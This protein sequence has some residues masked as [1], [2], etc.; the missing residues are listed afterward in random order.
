VWT[1]A[2]A[3]GLLLVGR[4]LFFSP[5]TLFG[6]EIYIYKAGYAPA[7]SVLLILLIGF[8]AANIFFW[9]RSLLLSF[10][11][12]ELPLRVSFLAMVA[13]VSLAF[14]LVPTLGY[15]AEAALFSAYFVISVSVLVLYGMAEIRKRSRLDPGLP[16]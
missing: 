2:V 1:G 7:Y 8:G 9:D 16:E 10:G 12:A 6:R 15:L 4:Q 14:L 5:W 3:A 13:K 11:R